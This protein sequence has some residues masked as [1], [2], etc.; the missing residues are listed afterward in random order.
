MTP[1]PN[2][3]V[4]G[5]W[6]TI[7]TLCRLAGAWLNGSDPRCP[8]SESAWQPLIE[9]ASHHLVT[10]AI[11]YGLRHSSG[12][13][14]TVEEYFQAVLFLNRD[15]NRVIMETLTGALQ[16]LNKAGIVPVLLKGAASIAGALYPD[17]AMRILGDLDVLVP[18]D[19]ARNAARVLSAI[20]YETVDKG[21]V[22]YSEHHH[23]APLRHIETGVFIE[24][25]TQPVLQELKSFL[26]A[27]TMI[28]KAVRAPFTQCSAFLPA[29]TH[30]IIHAIVHDQLSDGNYARR[31]LN[32]RQLLELAALANRHANDIDWEQVGKAF[33]A[34]G[35]RH[36]LEDGVEVAE[37]L[38]EVPLGTGLSRS[39]RQP[40]LGLKA[41]IERSDLHWLLRRFAAATRER[42]QLFLRVLQQ[43]AWA[44]LGKALRR[45]LRSE[46]W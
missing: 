14:S 10:P 20:G 8:H 32:I 6:E 37:A 34:N 41:E 46:R 42:P 3:N 12:L 22:R 24:L 43:D 40:L 13:P 35:Q 30:R 23:L 44:R 38:F 16:E 29:P 33:D 21:T 4:P 17:S 9:A 26:D 27:E 18:Q 2:G 1:M 19:Q 5:R 7:T 36:V 15:R 31:R 45:E 25:H 11:A 39:G 28:A